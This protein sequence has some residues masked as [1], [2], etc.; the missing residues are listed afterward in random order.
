MNSNKKKKRRNRAQ[1]KANVTLLK[2]VIR[3]LTYAKDDSACVVAI[4][5][6]TNKLEARISDKKHGDLYLAE[7]KSSKDF[8]EI[9]NFI[10]ENKFSKSAHICISDI[11]IR[12]YKKH[13][14]EN[15]NKYTQGLSDD[16]EGYKKSFGSILDVDFSFN[17]KNIEEYEKHITYIFNE[18]ISHNDCEIVSYPKDIDFFSNLVDKAIE[19][20]CPFVTINGN[21]KQYKDAGFKDAV[22]GE[23]ILRYSKNNNCK[24][25]LV[26]EDNDYSR[27]F[28]ENDDIHICKDSKQVKELLNNLLGLSDI[29]VVKNKFTNDHYLQET[30]IDLTGNKYDKS[31]TSFDV[32]DVQKIED[33][34][35]EISITTEI[36][37]VKYSI[38]C[39]YESSSNE[40]KYIKYDIQ[41][42]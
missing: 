10:V 35:Y 18:F 27:A 40:I 30:I 39:E 22:I 34:Q 38:K 24:C 11:S 37:E 1:R 19:K 42:E 2:N 31:V 29:D 7:I 25:I 3:D 17:K 14:I 9:R 33:G 32:L 23:T 6:D 15:Y 20:S 8:Y 36:N 28:S 16:I 26:S 12:E 41:N 21:G 13:L 4:F 5:F